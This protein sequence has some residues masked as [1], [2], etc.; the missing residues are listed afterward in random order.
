M[1]N[2]NGMDVNVQPRPALTFTTIGGII[3]F[4]LYLGPSPKDIVAQ[5][6]EIV[7]KPFLPPYFTL[8]FHLCRWKYNNNTNLKQV[9]HLNLLFNN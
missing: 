9:T 5:H 7:G 1:L 8:G 2:S 4:Y 6:S 3:D